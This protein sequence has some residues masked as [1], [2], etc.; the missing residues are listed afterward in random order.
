MLR[1]LSAILMVTMLAGC[2][3]LGGQPTLTPQGEQAILALIQIAT[4]VAAGTVPIQGGIN[5]ACAQLATVTPVGSCAVT[6]DPQKD[7]Q[8]CLLYSAEVAALARATAKV[9]TPTK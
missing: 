5:S 4:G 1:R 6:S 9:C 2:A 3:S 8:N 7:L